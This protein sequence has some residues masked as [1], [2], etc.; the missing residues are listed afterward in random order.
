[1]SSGS[2]TPVRKPRQHFTRSR[3]GCLACRKS[4]HKCDEAKP[5][6][7]RCIRY[8][9]TCQYPSHVSVSSSATP[10]TS[11]GGP[12]H[13]SALDIDIFDLPHAP[14]STTSGPSNSSG[15]AGGSVPGPST[16]AGH[17]PPTVTNM[18][19]Q[20]L[21]P[22]DLLEWVYPDLEE[23]EL[24]RHF[25][26]FGTVN[27]CAIPQPDKPIKYFDIINSIMNPRGSSLESDSL[28]ISILSIAAVH[29][30]SMFF[31]QDKGFLGE[32]PIG[33]WGA[34]PLP[35]TGP[36]DHSISRLRKVGENT[37]K[38]ALDLC[39]TAMVLKLEGTY[40]PKEFAISNKLLTGVMCIID[41]QE[42]LGGLLWKEAFDVGLELVKMRGG[43]RT[44]LELS[45]SS[46][47]ESLSTA[48]S[49][50]ENMAYI[51]M[52]RCMA[53]GAR[54]MVLL[55]AFEPW[56]FDFVKDHPP[57]SMDSFQ[58]AFGM[59]RGMLELANRVN[60]LVYEHTLLAKMSDRGHQNLHDHKI[61]D[62]QGELDLWE[63]RIRKEDKNEEFRRVT[64][65]NVIML[66]TLRILVLIDLL[67][68]SHLHDKVQHSAKTALRYLNDSRSWSVISLL[69]PTL[70]LAAVIA[71]P[72]GTATAKQVIQDLRLTTSFAYDVEEA[73][74]V[75]EKVKRFETKPWD[76]RLI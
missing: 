63:E 44:M 60:R 45:E 47:E 68:Y 9:R 20:E 22:P 39:R 35:I 14:T 21:S 27:M 59:D 10:P 42:M 4:K 72:A 1:M 49:V 50:L 2:G 70:I 3:T 65:G 29:R 74:N 34:P 76:H 36:S 75:F 15:V 58:Y 24:I 28:L 61:Q 7:Q 6:C 66:H 23:R 19:P 51:D 52:C 62:I 40:S 67:Q 13:L 11:G 46:S 8:S 37:S 69:V 33:P 17:H 53:S 31:Q 54:P 25:L 48:R 43:P 16:H 73:L 41:S 71:D 38:M 55:E 32:A 64:Y 18:I 12:A 26:A 57:D 56:W 5:I 30:S